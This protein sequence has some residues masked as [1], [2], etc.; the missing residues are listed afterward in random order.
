M[1]DYDGQRE[2]YCDDCNTF[3]NFKAAATVGKIT[4]CY[5][6]TEFV[7]MDKEFGLKGPSD[8]AAIRG[9]SGPSNSNGG[10]ANYYKLKVNGND[11]E[12][13]DIIEQVFG[14]DFDFGNNFKAMVRLW[15]LLNGGG[16]AGTSLEYDLNKIIYTCE[17]LKKR[18]CG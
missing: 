9:P 16:K 8:G 15:G 10:S 12:T 3:N 4:S 6:G 2:R 14:N 11:V 17:K 18:H 1:S 5:C 13:Q 7:A